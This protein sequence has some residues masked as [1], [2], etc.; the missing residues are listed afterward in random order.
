MP[1]ST[2]R[3]AESPH[4]EGALRR[5]RWRRAEPEAAYRR[6][7][8]LPG[9]A[10][11]SRGTGRYP[12]C[13]A[14][15]STRSRIRGARRPLRGARSPRM[16]VP[17]FPDGKRHLRTEPGEDG[18]HLSDYRIEVGSGQ[19]E[20]ELIPGQA[21]GQG[22]GRRT[23]GGQTIGHCGELGIAG[24]VAPSVVDRLEPVEVNQ[25]SDMRQTRGDLQFVEALRAGSIRQPGERIVFGQPARRG[26]LGTQ[27]PKP[28]PCNTDTEH[29]PAEQCQGNEE[30]YGIHS[31]PHVS[32][33]VRRVAP[34]GHPNRSRFQTIVRVPQQIQRLEQFDHGRH[35]VC[36]GGVPMRSA[37]R[38]L[39]GG[40]FSLASGD[41]TGQEF[42]RP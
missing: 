14:S 17:T 7:R 12:R 24:L 40:N 34:H 31:G 10:E 5:R 41:D 35:T 39:C 13:A 32:S 20:Q 29:E 6:C 26:Q 23:R 37:R 22:A 8:P 25:N 27:P 38:V 42:R 19:Q 16:A 3:C 2:T 36:S 30:R 4:D 15:P 1:L 18:R 11:P 33:G 21:A 9:R 28:P